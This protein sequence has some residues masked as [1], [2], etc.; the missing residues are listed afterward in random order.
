MNFYMTRL[1]GMFLRI[2][3]VISA[4]II[5]SYVVCIV[6]CKVGSII[7]RRSVD[8]ISDV[9]RVFST[10]HIEYNDMASL[11]QAFTAKYNE[12]AE[13]IHELDKLK[14]KYPENQSLIQKIDLY[15]AYQLSMTNCEMQCPEHINNERIGCHKCKGTGK[16]YLGM[17]K[18]D[19]CKGDGIIDCTR[20]CPNCCNT[21]R[22]G[23]PAK[24]LLGL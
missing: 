12:I 16:R 6:S 21:E 4:L 23:I 3:A 2:L 7:E 22:S 14:T 18:C 17:Q 11:R 1:G 24:K 8:S 10:E 13:V 15:R 9:P 20:I 5:L 19:Y